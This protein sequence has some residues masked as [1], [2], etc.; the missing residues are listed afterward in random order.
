MGK[1]NHMCKNNHGGCCHSHKEIA[2]L[3]LRLAVGFVFLAHGLDKLGDMEKTIG[4]FAS[5]GI[6]AF[7][8]YVVAWVETL[9]GIALI[10]GIF[11]R[12]ASRLLALVMVVAIALVKSKMGIR[13]AEIDLVLLASTILLA[14]FGSGSLSISRFCKCHKLGG[15]EC[16]V[17]KFMGCSSCEKSASEK[18]SDGCCGEGKD[19]G[20]CEVK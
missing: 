11:T 3:L 12:H 9:G 19:C 1:L 20:T 10:I 13:S 15:G 17:C 16:K 2:I 5:V 6:P 7:L 14:T 18:C 4:F 8:A